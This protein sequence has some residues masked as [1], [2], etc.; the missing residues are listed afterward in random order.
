[1]K[2]RILTLMKKEILHIIR[3]PRS[4]YLALLLPVVLLILFGFAITFDLHHLPIGIVDQDRTPVSRDLISRLSSSEYFD[5][6]FISHN[7][8]GFDRLLEEGKVK[9]ILV[10]PP[11]FSRHLDRAEKPSLQLLIDGS[12][13]NTAQVAMGYISRLIQVFS[14]KMLIK[15]L[16]EQ[17]PQLK[18]AIPPISA[19]PRIWYNPELN[20]TNF[21]IPGLIAVVMMVLT[22]LLTS[23]TIAREWETGTIEQ[24]IITPARSSEIIIGKVMPYIFLGYLQISLV[25]LA[26]TLLFGVPFK[27]SLILLFFVS[28]IFLVCGLG[29]GLLIST[30]SKSQQLAF[31]LSIL[32]TLLP[33]F[34]LS[35]FIFPV[36]SMPLLIQ[37]ITWL[38]PA[39]YFLVILRGIFLKGNGLA[40]LWPQVLVL[41]LFALFFLIASSKRLKLTLE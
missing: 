26:G 1:M 17:S 25:I 7:Y 39:K 33:S 10:F 16:K 24:L 34:L 6:R 18:P 21:I 12:D 27:G 30:V 5:I 38:V 2:R 23:L 22:A 13:N 41:A 11:Q 28:G 15:K 36:S 4:L 14:T 35:G 8:S 32:F 3:D 37:Y 9:L 40:I 29:I 31:M 20:S 19:Q